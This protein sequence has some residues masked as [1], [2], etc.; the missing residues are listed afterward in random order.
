MKR[1]KAEALLLAGVAGL[2]LGACGESVSSLSSFS[3]ASASVSASAE[4]SHENTADSEAAASSVLIA[5]FS[6]TGENYGVGN[7]SVGNTAV[8]AGYIHE[9]TSSA[10]FEIVPSVSYPS[11]YNETLSIATSEKNS[12]A[13]PAIQS[14]VGDFSSYSTVFLGYPIWWGSCPQIILTFLDTYDWSG[15]TIVPFCTSG[16]SSI[17]SSASRL[18]AYVPQAVFKEGLGIQGTSIRDSQAKDTV[19]AWLVKLGFEIKP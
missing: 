1:T 12:D 5:Y 13:R 17:D 19:Q 8:M 9:L 15:K 3:A 6:R 2:T 10:L 11:S 18:A 4:A 14:Q 7:I 16:G